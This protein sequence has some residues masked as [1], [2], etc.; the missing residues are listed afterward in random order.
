MVL[1]KEYQQ[2]IELLRP[3]TKLP[4]PSTLSRDVRQVYIDGSKLVRE[5][6]IVSIITF[7]LSTT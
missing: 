4:H 3:G 6:F 1:D 2:E 5:Y 7:L